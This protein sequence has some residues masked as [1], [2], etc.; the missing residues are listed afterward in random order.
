MISKIHS[1]A[2]QLRVV[3]LVEPSAGLW[4]Q[5][6]QVVESAVQM[7]VSLRI[8]LGGLLR[9]GLTISAY[10]LRSKCL[11]CCQHIGL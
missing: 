9:I 4:Q 8:H 1:S 2:D 3:L 6:P 10:L 11:V 5:G 7:K